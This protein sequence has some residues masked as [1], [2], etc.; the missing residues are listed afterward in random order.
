MKLTTFV[1]W[2][3]VERK[4]SKHGVKAPFYICYYNLESS[5]VVRERVEVPGFEWL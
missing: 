2:V 5:S 1:L 3:L 4:W